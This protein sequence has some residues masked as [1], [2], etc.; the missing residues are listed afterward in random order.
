MGE[1][2]NRVKE[3]GRRLLWRFRRSR[4]ERELEEE[5]AHHL[6]MSGGDA[7]AHRRFGNVTSIQE[8]SRSMWTFA[9]WE[10]CV[11]DF[12]YA[13]RALSANKLFTAMAADRAN[14]RG[15]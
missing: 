15:G 3:T 10:Q 1:L 11:Q 5:I 4:Y 13:V 14:R 2:A 12:R 9:V 8:E 7:A 6:A